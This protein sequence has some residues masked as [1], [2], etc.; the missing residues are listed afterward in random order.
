MARSKLKKFLD[1]EQMPNVLQ[2]SQNN[3]QSGLTAFLRPD[4]KTTLE[5]GCGHG[6]YT[7]TL[8]GENSD[9]QFIGI[10]LQGE[11]LWYAANLALMGNLNNV[12]FLRIPI[13]NILDYLTPHSIDTIWLAFPDPWPKK[14]RHRKRLTAERFQKIYKTLLKTE[15]LVHC[16]TDDEKFFNF[17]VDTIKN[18]RG[19]IHKTI[20]NIY[21]NKI[22]EPHI[23]IQ[24]SFEKSYLLRGKNIHYICW[25]P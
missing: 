24:T 6:K 19:K 18:C 2:Y 17:T 16:K 5:L 21:K 20:K 1:L 8:A 23:F 13:E 9:E 12:L 15:G 14:G 10:D 25:R 4:K 7:L 3:I 22:N 11:R